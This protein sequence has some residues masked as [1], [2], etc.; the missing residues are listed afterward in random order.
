MGNWGTGISSNDTF[1][2]IKDE[3]FEL[4]NEGLETNE[5]TRKIIISNQEIVNEK[6]DS[7]NFW[8]ALALCQWECKSLDPE[9]L[10]R[11]TKI[12][13]S[14][15]D[16]KLWRELGAEK[17][18]LTIRKNVLDKFL[19][20]LNS[21]KKSPKRRKK[22]VYRDAIFQKGNCLSVQL[23]NGSFGAAFVLESEEQTEYGLNLIALCDYFSVEPPK[24]QFFEEATVLI[25]KQQ[26]SRDTYE[27]YP[28][29]SWYM[30]PH[31]KAN[32]VNLTVI[33]SL[34]SKK[35]F[36]CEKDYPRFVHWQYIPYHIENQPDLVAKHGPIQT[37]LKLKSLRKKT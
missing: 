26:A 25:S 9:L 8:F 14:G 17:S 37:E 13:K 1:E 36:N 7:N 12:V 29:I 27:D 2:D 5:I 30:A 11:I 21:E 34:G 15:T 6:E 28:L 24:I 22:K 35:T 4:Y 16:I 3:F 19:E 32:E 18:E 33:G 23:S 10:E 31:F 20:K